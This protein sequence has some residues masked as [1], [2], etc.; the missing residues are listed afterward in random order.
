MLG[1]CD[2]LGDGADRLLENVVCN[3]EGIGKGDLLIGDKFQAVG[4]MIKESTLSE[5]LAMPPSA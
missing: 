4:M 2:Q 5:R 3:A 1:V